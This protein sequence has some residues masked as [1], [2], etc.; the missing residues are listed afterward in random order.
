MRVMAVDFNKVP[1]I[2]V[3]SCQNYIYRVDSCQFFAK[4][5]EELEI[6]YFRKHRSDTGMQCIEMYS[7]NVFSFICKMVSLLIA[8]MI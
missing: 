4:H 2:C 8:S 5:S 3:L 6:A 1:I 7:V